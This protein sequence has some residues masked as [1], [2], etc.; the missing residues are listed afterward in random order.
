MTVKEIGQHISNA[1]SGITGTTY[2]EFTGHLP[3]S[4][5]KGI[6][7]TIKSAVLGNTFGMGAAFSITLRSEKHDE[8][9]EHASA[10]RK[11]IAGKFPDTI[12]AEIPEQ[13]FSVEGVKGAF[14]WIW[15]TSFDI[16][17]TATEG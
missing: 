1:A 13:D 9:I 8:L 2:P 16:I 11:N 6:C 4:V 17:I 15:E 5:K 10:L 3:L 12:T 7:Y 14:R